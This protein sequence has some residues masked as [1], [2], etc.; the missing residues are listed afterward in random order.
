MKTKTRTIRSVLSTGIAI[1]VT[2]TATPLLAEVPQAVTIMTQVVFNA[3]GGG[4][5]TFVATGPICSTG[6]VFFED[7]V[8]AIGPAAFNVN[9]LSEFV[10]DDNSGTFILRVHPQA[11]GRP[12]DGFALNGPWSVWG[13]GTGNYASLSGHGEFG[14][15][16]D[17]D[18]DP[19]KGEETYVGFVTLIEN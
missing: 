5:G 1:A 17:F 18:A 10:C 4:N 11:S 12:K 2:C 7:Q 14:V 3:E 13:K 19:L 6:T 9:G 16:F 15:V 8:F